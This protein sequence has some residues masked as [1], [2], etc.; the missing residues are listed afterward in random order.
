MYLLDIFTVTANLTGNP[1]LSVPMGTVNRK[2]YPE[3]EE[4][5]L[6]VG[7]QFTAAHGDEKTLFEVGK[8]LEGGN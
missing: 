6:P 8:T 7:I 2:A 4:K 1:A 3:G 5:K